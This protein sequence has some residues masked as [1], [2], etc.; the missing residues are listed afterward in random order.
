MSTLKFDFD[1]SSMAGGALGLTPTSGSKTLRILFG[2]FDIAFTAP[3]TVS[4]M[5]VK[6]DATDSQGSAFSQICFMM[7]AQS[8][9]QVA[10]Q[11]Q[12]SM[13]NWLQSAGARLSIGTHQVHSL[14]PHRCK[15]T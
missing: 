3:L 13:Q 4:V 6:F 7:A 14:A 5:E 12:L 2:I 10:T 15:H 11:I 1:S 9:S 8:I